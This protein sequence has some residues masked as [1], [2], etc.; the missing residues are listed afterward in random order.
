[1]QKSKYALWALL[2]LAVLVGSFT[3]LSPAESKP[4]RAL[5]PETYRQIDLF[6]DVLQ[7][8]RDGYVDKP[9]QA[10]LIE[11]AINGMLS[12]LDPHS[13][14]MNAQQFRDMQVQESGRFGGVGIEVTL[15]DGSL[16][17]V[18]PIEGTPAAN[19]GI[20]PGD[21][22]TAID[23]DDTHGMSLDDAVQHMRGP[24]NVPVTLSISRSGVRDAFDVRIVREVIQVLPVKYE[25]ELECGLY[26]HLHL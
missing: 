16:K 21:L 10:K 19:A 24:A 1:M 12:G 13:F 22:I 23:G 5:A 17:I 8:I 9:D 15:Q 2:V 4:A 26:P 6:E 18:A 7:R 14:Y 11:G 20:L 25:I 3:I